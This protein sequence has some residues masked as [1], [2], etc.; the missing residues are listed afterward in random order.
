[1]NFATMIF[2]GKNDGSIDGRHYF[3]CEEKHDILLGPPLLA[4]VENPHYGIPQ[5]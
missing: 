5:N 3:G 1:M 2:W 4:E